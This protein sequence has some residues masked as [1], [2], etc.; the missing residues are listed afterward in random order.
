MSIEHDAYL[1]IIFEKE[2]TVDLTSILTAVEDT[3]TAKLSGQAK[4]AADQDKRAS[5]DAVIN[6]DTTDVAS[7]TLAADQAIDNATA[8]LASLRSVPAPV[9]VTSA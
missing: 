7:L 2:N 4:L 5:L 8:A 6:Q 3:Q 9:T 1:A